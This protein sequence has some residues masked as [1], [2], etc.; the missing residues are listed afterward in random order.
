MKKSEELARGSYLLVVEN[1]PAFSDNILIRYRKRFDHIE[2]ARR[3]E[4]GVDIAK[5]VC[6]DGKIITMAIVDLCMPM[7]DVSIQVPDAGFVVVERIRQLSWFR[8]WAP[9]VVIQTQ[10]A[11][12]ERL[13]SRDSGV[14]YADRARSLSAH[15]VSRDTDGWEILD[16]CME[17]AIAEEKA[18]FE[19]I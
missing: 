19:A 15:Y 17:R 14:A 7:K 8:S 11:N 10:H 16:S 12:E 13:R 1:D 4:E 2:V 9:W 3:S 5:S 18:F 6:G